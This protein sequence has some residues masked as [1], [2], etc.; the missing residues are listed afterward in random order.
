M[1]S[2]ATPE[3]YEARYGPFEDS[4]RLA[5]LLADASAFIQQQPGF[6]E[7]TTDVK[8]QNLTRVTCAVVYRSLSAGELAGL[9]S[10]SQGGVGYSAS[11]TPYNP[12]GDFYL[13]KTEKKTL[14]LHGAQIGTV[15]A[16]IHDGCGEVVWPCSTSQA[17][18]NS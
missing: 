9:Q 6:T 17:S 13:T 14:G 5:T 4:A 15:Y 16:A 1:D 12:S 3:D 18:P 10:Y 2:F 7:P 8:T 11:V